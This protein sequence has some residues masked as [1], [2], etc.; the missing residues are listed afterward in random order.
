VIGGMPAD[1]LVVVDVGTIVAGGAVT[2][3]Y[4]VAIDDSLNPGT[5]FVA[6]QGVASATGMGA[7]LTDDPAT[8]ATSD[9]TATPVSPAP[10]LAATKTAVLVFDADGD[11]VVSPGDTLHYTITMRNDGDA[12]AAA[13][14]ARDLLL[15]PQLALVAGSVTT[16]LGSVTTGNGVGDTAVEVAVGTLSGAGGVATVEFDALLSP[17]F[18]AGIAGVDNQASVTSANAPTLSTDDPG[19]PG[20]SD[21]TSVPVAATPDVTASKD[22]FLLVDG[23]GDGVAAPGDTI[24]YTVVIAN[25]GTL[26][27]TGVVFADSFV[28]PLL[29][30]V[31]GS[32]TTT[33]GTIT[34]GNEPGATTVEVAV[35]SL[36]GAG[37]SVTVTFDAT[38]S[39]SVP[40][41]TTSVSNV[42]LV[43]ATPTED[44]DGGGPTVTPLEV[45]PDLAVTKTDS[46]VGAGPG[47][48][49]VYTISYWNQGTE[50]AAGVVLTETVPAHSS[51]NAVASGG[52]WS[53]PDGP[54][55]GTTC[56]LPVGAVA[57]STGGSAVFAVTVDGS[58]P[59]G[60]L[61]LSNTT[62][63]ADGGSGSPDIDSTNNTFT[64]ASSLGEA[65][66]TGSVWVDLNNDGLFDTDEPPLAGIGLELTH[67]AS[68]TVTP[69]VV[70]A[71]GSFSFG[72]L[73]AG[74]F[75][76]EVDE[77]TVPAGIIP[78]TP[79]VGLISSGPGDSVDSGVITVAAGQVWAA[80]F[81][82]VGA[83]S[84]GG[85]VW[86]DLDGNG[87]LDTGEPGLG[88][89]SVGA[90][91]SGHT[92]AAVS[93]P[94]G[95]YRF[96]NLPPD[97]YR[98]EV[99][100]GGPADAAV[101]AGGLPILVGLAP[102]V[103]IDSVDIGYHAMADLALAVNLYDAPN[104]GSPITYIFTVTNNGPASSGPVTLMALLPGGFDFTSAADA[105]WTCTLTTQL[106]CTGPAMAGGASTPVVVNGMVTGSD[107][108]TLT[109]LG[110]V[111]STTPDNNL[112]NN[113]AALSAGIGALPQTGINADRVGLSGLLLLLAGG[114]LLLWAVLADRRRREEEEPFGG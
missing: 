114:F 81:P 113:Q 62:S 54:S 23:D 91:A 7:D 67:I 73:A 92:W 12:H 13:V 96:D 49:L 56:T 17:A 21:P 28:D 48:T 71:D 66:I 65:L 44:P 99:T 30:L 5:V 11:T 88:G 83:G 52:A 35:G 69:G 102:G 108:V 26:E 107:G 45:G 95:S 33:G 39:D 37:G 55:A 4:D 32:V 40:G 90:S 85:I 84:I 105:G 63:I 1:T 9:P 93:D 86:S 19:L 110:A 101:T 51:F 15:D 38:I 109:I 59:V 75:V 43:G 27:A 64:L 36:A 61:A 22:D 50:N 79:A 47:A 77:A 2:V 78:T 25:D 41:G 42:G 18:P 68:A 70:A 6:T 60:V 8:V 20:P 111:S 97:T 100:A 58:I 80:D 24:R 106:V 74:S 57:T 103:D 87:E 10:L 14:V 112:T 3:T 104:T 98:I 16:N 29:T 89:V 76:V 46:G 53:C 94:S 31:A 72:G 34:T 82:H